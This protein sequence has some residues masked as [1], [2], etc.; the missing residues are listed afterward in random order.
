L[1]INHQGAR[2]KLEE[3][4]RYWAGDRKQNQLGI[5]QDVIDSL[6]AANAPPAIIEAARNSAVDET[7]DCDVW[8]ENMLPVA[9]FL[10]VSTQ[11]TISPTGQPLGVNY[12][13]LESAM[14][15]AKVKQK[16]RPSLFDDVRLMESIALEVFREK[17]QCQH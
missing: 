7:P 2:K 16:K 5:D 11:W 15:M 17:A 12:V 8:E 9:V 1:G 3:V 14:N 10:S 4:A 13:A 6:I